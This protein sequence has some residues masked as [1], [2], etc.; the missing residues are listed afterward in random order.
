VTFE[1][2]AEGQLIVAACDRQNRHI[3][4]R[5]ADDDILRPLPDNGSEQFD[6]PDR[7]GNDAAH[8]QVDC[9]GQFRLS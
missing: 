3:A 2:E 1:P 7:T 4:V 9:G 5:H 6:M 8:S